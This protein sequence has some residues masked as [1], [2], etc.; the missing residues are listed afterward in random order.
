M[1]SSGVPCINNYFPRLFFA[2]VIIIIIV[3]V[4]DDDDDDD[5][6]SFPNDWFKTKEE[7]NPLIGR[8]FVIISLRKK[9]SIGIESTSLSLSKPK[10]D[11]R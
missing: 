1:L 5:S 10:T 8:S 4:D 6:I 11:T 7:L 9:G 2:S 3:V